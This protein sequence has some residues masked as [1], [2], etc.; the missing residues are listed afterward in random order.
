MTAASQRITRLLGEIEAGKS[1]SADELV[2]LLYGELRRLASSY[3]R[4]ERPGHTLQPTA[5]VNEAYLKLVEQRDI[6]WSGRA[7]FIG[8]AARV[9]RQVL[10]D[11]ARR[12]QAL[13]RGG[14][15][16]RLT[17]QEALVYSREQPGDLLAIDELLGRLA[18]LD[19][20]QAEIVELRTFGGL[21]VEETAEALSISAATVKR[22]WAIAKA[23]LTREL[24]R[25]EKS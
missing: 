4:R 12:G 17:L 23:W 9:M 3:L 15:K 22:E 20:R 10:V 21:T 8:I 5:L 19:A 24:A 13:R 18:A 11:H 7:H 6:A 1:A 16:P 25:G 14:G 2:P